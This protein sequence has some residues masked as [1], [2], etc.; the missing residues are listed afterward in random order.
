MLNNVHV[1]N[2][3]VPS[4]VLPQLSEPLR[5][6]TCS[7]NRTN[8]HEI[9]KNSYFVFTSDLTLRRSVVKALTSIILSPIDKTVRLWSVVILAI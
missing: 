2:K 6:K 5:T 9:D 3:Q 8:I 4:T 1:L 7:D